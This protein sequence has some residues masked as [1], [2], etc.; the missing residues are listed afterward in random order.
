[1]AGSIGLLLVVGLALL[2]LAGP[3]L[4][5]G[6]DA[7]WQRIQQSGIWRVGMD[8]S[9]PP[10]DLLDGEGQPT[11]YD[12]ELAQ[13]LARRWDVELQ[14]VAIGFDGLTDALLA[15]KIESVISALPYDP[16]LTEDL[17]YSA[18]YFEA[19]IRLAVRNDSPVQSVGDLAGRRLAVEWGS[20]GD[21]IARRLQ[22]EDPSL[23]RLTFPG[24]QEALQALLTGEADGLLIDGVS[25]R[26]FQGSGAALKAAGPALESNPYAIA[27]PVTAHLLRQEIDAAL[28][29][30]VTTGFL[31]ELED[32]WFSEEKTQ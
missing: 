20:N 16:R 23:Q 19:G 1:M 18:S 3:Y 29:E 15:G 17:S 22:R 27:L 12:V 30:F 28:T 9:F 31:A 32:R 6:E 5:R 25:L 24:G 4:G 14:I 8:P 21:A 10:F 26:L 2:W 13:A 7:T 11:G